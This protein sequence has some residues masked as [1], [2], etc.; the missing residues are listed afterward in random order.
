[1]DE[2]SID[3][4]NIEAIMKCTIPINYIED[5]SFVGASKYLGNFISLFSAVATPLHTI[6][7]SNKSFQW[8]KN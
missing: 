2:R 5:R 1:M 6:T 8:G 3:P 7:V 4:V